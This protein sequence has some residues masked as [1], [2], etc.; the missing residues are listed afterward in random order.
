MSEINPLHHPRFWNRPHPGEYDHTQNS[1]FSDKQSHFDSGEVRLKLISE[2]F[3]KMNRR[4]RRK[5]ERDISKLRLKN[6]K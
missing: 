6:K 4:E 2:V 5:L 1:I 3:G